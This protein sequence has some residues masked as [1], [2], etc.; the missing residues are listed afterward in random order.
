M[1]SVIAKKW[2]G[3]LYHRMPS[4]VSTGAIFH[5][6]IRCASGNPV[7]M[8]ESSLA[9]RIIESVRFYEEQ[10]KWYV[11]LFLLMPDHLHALL[12]FS[13][14]PGMAR[15]IAD[16]K[17]FH[18]H[19]NNIVWQQNFFDHRIRNDDELIE[20]AAYIRRNP[21]AKGLCTGED[22]WPWVLDRNNIG[23]KVEDKRARSARS[24]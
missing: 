4:W 15:I 3:R 1:N 5:I 23:R 6:R 22:A 13:G 12:S 17:H 8:T 16:W 7:P 21:L 11:T 18:S 9:A 2:P 20:K 10:R 19:N 14:V 24:T